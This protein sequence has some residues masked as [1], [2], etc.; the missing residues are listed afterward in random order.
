MGREYILEG[1]EDSKVGEWFGEIKYPPFLDFENARFFGK[2]VCM[3]G[4]NQTISLNTTTYPGGTT[5][6]FHGFLFELGKDKWNVKKVDEK[7]SVSPEHQQ[8]WQITLGQKEALEHKIK[9]ALMTI[10]NSIADLELVMMDFNRYKTY[11]EYLEDLNSKDPEKKRTAELTLK[12]IFV[13]QV[14]YHA[15]GE[16]QGPGRFSMAFMRNN[17]I[18][19]TIVQDFLEM[20]S[21]EDLKTGKLKN[22]PK[23][24]KNVLESKWRAYQDWLNIFRS[25]VERRLKELEVLVRSREKTIEEMREW[26]KPIIARYKMLNDALEYPGER[27]AEFSSKIRLAG[28][29]YALYQST[30]WIYKPF[31]L[32]EEFPAPGELKAKDMNLIHPLKDG[33]SLDHLVLNY[34]I[35]LSVKFPWITEEW[36]RNLTGAILKELKWEGRYYM[37]YSFMV[38]NFIRCNLRYANGAEIEDAVWI[39]TNWTTSTNVIWTKLLEGFALERELE[40]YMD[41]ILGLKH[42]IEGRPVIFYKKKNGKYFIMQDHLNAL[43]KFIFSVD[44]DEFEIGEKKLVFSSKKDMEKEFPPKKFNLKKVDKEVGLGEKAR[45]FFRFFGIDLRWRRINSPYSMVAKDFGNKNI[46]KP[47]GK[48]FR[49]VVDKLIKRM[50]IGTIVKSP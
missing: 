44:G 21:L 35:G 1:P 17:N 16:G 14:D 26:V 43:K 49:S 48:R 13:D 37:L 27:A 34:N 33:W 29:M 45:D 11:K 8:Y 38:V 22:I 41:D 5:G 4:S 28:N 32:F 19:P 31:P 12:S 24:E 42:K 25:N 3:R 47:Q 18:L 15:G 50:K 6:A 9:Q 23:V 2:A 46:L 36:V 20:E 7:I 10:S 30:F 40:I 39:V